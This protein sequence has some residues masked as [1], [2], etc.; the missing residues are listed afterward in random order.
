[1]FVCM[2]LHLL[3]SR[4]FDIKGIYFGLDFGSKNS[5]QMIESYHISYEIRR[6]APSR[7]LL[8]LVKRQSS[9][10]TV[11]ARATKLEATS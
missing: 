5:S 6:L 1:M 3:T 8:S 7:G 2:Y 4:Y 11:Q 9:E 10:R